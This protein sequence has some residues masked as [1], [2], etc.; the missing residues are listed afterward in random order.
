MSFNHWAVAWLHVVAPV[1]TLLDRRVPGLTMPFDLVWILLLRQTTSNGD[2][3]I[4]QRKLDASRRVGNHKVCHTH[5]VEAVGRRL[6]WTA[7]C[8]IKPA[9]RF[10][11]KSRLVYWE[12]PHPLVDSLQFTRSLQGKIRGLLT[13]GAL[14]HISGRT[15]RPEKQLSAYRCQML[16]LEY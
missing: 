11:V 13:L 9:R 5:V 14:C 4:E 3:E 2:V 6:I 8:L 7:D 16:V 1:E 10:L 12:P 15:C